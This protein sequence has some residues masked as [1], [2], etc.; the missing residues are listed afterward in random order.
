[1][2]FDHTIGSNDNGGHEGG[3]VRKIEE[4]FERAPANLE[5]Y[6]GAKIPKA[7]ESLEGGMLD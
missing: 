4:S 7:P 1:M 3:S 5:M 6:S 2:E